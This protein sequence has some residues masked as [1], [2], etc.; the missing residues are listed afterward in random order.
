IRCWD[1]NG[2][3]SIASPP[4][5]ENVLAGNVPVQC[6]FVDFD[7]ESV[8]FGQMETSG[9]D[10]PWAAQKGL[11]VSQNARLVLLDEETGHRHD[12]MEGRSDRGPPQHAEVGSD[13]SVKRVCQSP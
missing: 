11:T 5:V 4:S 13:R 12:G 8:P 2:S 7:A 6:L 3:C 1:E 9:L 10:P